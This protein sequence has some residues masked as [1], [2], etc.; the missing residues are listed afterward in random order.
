[1]RGNWYVNVRKEGRRSELHA[2]R[3]LNFD[4]P[5]Q[6][7][8]KLKPNEGNLSAAFHHP[9]ILVSFFFLGPL[10]KLQHV[11]STNFYLLKKK[12]YKWQK[13][14]PHLGKSYLLVI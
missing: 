10:E 3:L 13:L 4:F 2:K 8:G 5:C 9:P 12:M 11:P 7:F 6:R 1:M 14:K